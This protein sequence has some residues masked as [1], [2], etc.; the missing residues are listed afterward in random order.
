MVHPVGFEPTHLAAPEPE[1]GV[2]A[3]FTTGAFG[4]I[5]YHIVC[6]PRKGVFEKSFASRPDA[7]TS[8]GEGYAHAAESQV[9]ARHGNDQGK[10]Q[11]ISLGGASRVGRGL[12]ITH[13]TAYAG[14][15]KAKKNGSVSIKTLRSVWTF[16]PNRLAS[17]AHTPPNT[18]SSLLLYKPPFPFMPRII[19]YIAAPPQRRQL[20]LG[21]E[22]GDG[23]VGGGVE[24]DRLAVD[25]LYGY[26]IAY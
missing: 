10:N 22:S 12:R 11:N 24:D 18:T 5:V 14:I 20:L 6:P 4:C 23:L 16:Q 25:E 17:P 1:S 2:Y 21:G 3:N 19:P 7:P 9:P 8:E 13:N 26:D 15:V